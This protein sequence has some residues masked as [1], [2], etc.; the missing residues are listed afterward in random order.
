[1]NVGTLNKIA[2]TKFADIPTEGIDE[3]FWTDTDA[4]AVF[5]GMHLEKTLPEK[6]PPFATHIWGW[7]DNRYI[8]IRVD[9]SVPHGFAAVVFTEGESDEPGERCVFRQQGNLAVGLGLQ[10]LVDTAKVLSVRRKDN[11]ETS[12]EFV[13]LY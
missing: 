4:T 11:P 13:R 3:W 7:G 6:I 5:A 10:N 9:K 2:A 8:R 12:V 1:M